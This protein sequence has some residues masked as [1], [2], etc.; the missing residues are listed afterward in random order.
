M[1]IL[2]ERL[3]ATPRLHV[4]ELAGSWWDGVFAAEARA[5]LRALGPVHFEVSASKLG[6][7]ILLSGSAH[8][9]VELECGRCLSRYR[10]E[11]RE[12]FRLL[13]EPA[14]DRT[15]SDPEGA[16]SLS[17]VGVWLGDDPGAGWYRGAEID[18]EPFCRE[19]LLLALPV[20]PLCGEACLGL[21]PHCGADRNRAPC[22]CVEPEPVSPFAAL[23]GLRDRLRGAKGGS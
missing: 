4:F 7:D 16:A 22:A 14:G 23:A 3:D 5:P 21:C 13:L 18:L 15:P 6:E 17:R 2:I 8:A 11:L 10:Q 9:E 19:L 12:A 1:K 20:Q